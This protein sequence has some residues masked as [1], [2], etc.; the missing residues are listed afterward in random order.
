MS[1]KQKF[2]L[3]KVAQ[4]LLLVGFTFVVFYFMAR[5]FEGHE[6]L[7]VKFAPLVSLLG[8]VMVLVVVFVFSTKMFHDMPQDGEETETVEYLLPDGASSKAR[9]RMAEI[10]YSKPKEKPREKFEDVYQV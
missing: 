7:G 4:L 6:L 9:A 8:L 3:W 10:K 2:A 5:Q 1:S